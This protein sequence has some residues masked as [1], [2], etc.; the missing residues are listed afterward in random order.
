MKS[1][2]E[3]EICRIHKLKLKNRKD[4]KGEFCTECDAHETRPRS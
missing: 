1:T 3:Q 2:I 4:K